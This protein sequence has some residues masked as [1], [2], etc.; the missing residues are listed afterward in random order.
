MYYKVCC[1]N[2][3]T[4]V[5]EFIS[6]AFHIQLARPL[7]CI[8]RGLQAEGAS[9]QV[10]NRTTLLRETVEVHALRPCGRPAAAAAA[11][12]LFDD[13]RQ[14]VQIAFAAIVDVRC[15]VQ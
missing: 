4:V 11:T 5:R 1:S 12:G 10:A 6:S 15:L 8:P 3:P 7:D 14:T 9:L 13:Y 2:R